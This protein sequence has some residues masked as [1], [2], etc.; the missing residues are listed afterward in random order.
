[1]SNSDMDLDLLSTVAVTT[2]ETE[3]PSDKSQFSNDAIYRMS[4]PTLSEIM[5][6]QNGLL[7]G[8]MNPDPRISRGRKNDKDA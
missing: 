7:H 4:F 8:S 6:G 5:G 3:G 2:E 1:M